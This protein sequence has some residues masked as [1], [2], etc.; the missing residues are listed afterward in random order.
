MKKLIFK[1][2]TKDIS[3]FF[4]I[5]IIS[6]ATIVWIIQAVNYLDL[7]SEDGHSL[8]VYFLY[9][10]FSLPKIISKILP[11]IFLISLFYVIISYEFNNELIIYWING[12]TKLNFVNI[13]IKIS[14]IYFLIQLILTTLI[15]PYSLDKGR[16]YFRTSNVDLFTSIIKEKKFIDTV[17]DLTIFVETKE[18]NFLKNIIIKE[19]I[20]KDKSQIIVAQSGKI[21]SGNESE[22]KIILNNGKI[23]N[24]ENNNQNIIDFSKFNLDL[25][26]F[27]TKTVT[28]QKTQELNTI[29]LL[30]CIKTIN[31]FRHT[32]K[33]ATDKFFFMGCNLGITE[34]IL[35]EF[36][37]RFF[38]PLFI[39]L[40]GLAS[41]LIISS[42]KDEM[43]YKSRNF[44]KFIVGI[45]VII[46]SEMVLSSAFLNIG[47]LLFY[48]IIPLV[49]FILLYTYIYLNHNY[50]KTNDI[51]HS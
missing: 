39:I 20:N 11:F 33:N 29:N 43:N 9:T 12:I 27:S 7:I 37:K 17:E 22:K 44:I 21:I 5:S 46:I 13:I 10:L 14:V 32:N 42:S 51:K 4:F 2:L 25:N 6:V 47:N 18:N 48:F 40:I 3:L 38:A 8:Q 28:H 19:K 1:K 23:I 50:F 34:P 24:T 35:E 36:L 15:V 31:E 30:R 49:L 45:I 26:K 16:S 41:S